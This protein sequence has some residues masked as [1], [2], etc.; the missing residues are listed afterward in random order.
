MLFCWFKSGGELG[1]P[2]QVLLGFQNK[3][4]FGAENVLH[5]LQNLFGLKFGKEK[6]PKPGY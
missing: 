1:S 5:V 2:F 3:I 6:N 4:H